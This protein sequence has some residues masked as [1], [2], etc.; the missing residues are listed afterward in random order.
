M[1]PSV[2]VVKVST[3]QMICESL[4]IGSNA[5]NGSDDI[6]GKKRGVVEDDDDYDDFDASSIW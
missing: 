6:L 1:Q 5:Y 4:R 2:E 3:T